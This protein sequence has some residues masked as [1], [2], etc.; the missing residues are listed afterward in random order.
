MYK[1]KDKVKLINS[2]LYGIIERIKNDNIT[3]KINNK[4][5]ITNVNKIEKCD[6][7]ENIIKSRSKVILNNTSFNGEIMLRHMTTDEALYELDNF[8]DLAIIYKAD[9]IKII[10]GKSGGIL[11]KAVSKYL[12]DNKYIKSFNL[13][14]Y[15]EG[16]YGVT[17]AY[18]K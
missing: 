14:E 8:I 15:H 3:I 9:K 10:H 13:G 11:R 7:K 5:I 12:K 6:F 18:L 16:S 1:L 4:N 17:I 2:S